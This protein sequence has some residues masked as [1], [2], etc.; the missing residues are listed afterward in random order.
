[1]PHHP[2][3]NADG[4]N[5]LAL[6]FGGG[7]APTVGDQRANQNHGW[8]YRMGGGYRYNSRASLLVEYTFD[9]FDVPP[10][11]VTIVAGQG[12]VSASGVLHLWS[13]TLVPT[14][15]FAQKER[16][17]AYVLGGGGYYR[18]NFPGYNNAPNA[19]GAGGFE[20][21]VGIF[22]PLTAERTVKLFAEARFVWIGGQ[23]PTNALPSPKN[24][25]SFIP[26]TAGL[27]W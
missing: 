11:D 20:G 6:E 18:K 17:S 16:Y 2:W 3:T 5:R 12:S 9:H 10:H 19:A 7:G 13:T 21:G 27:R 22:E 23:T 14:Y 24:R 26:I 4:S 25:T 8:L 1:M 15:E